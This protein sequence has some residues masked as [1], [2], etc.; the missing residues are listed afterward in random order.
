MLNI[1]CDDCCKAVPKK[2][3]LKSMF[4]KEVIVSCP[5]CK[6]QYKITGKSQWILGFILILVP[7]LSSSILNHI[8]DVDIQTYLIVESSVFFIMVI[9]SLYLVN[10]KKVS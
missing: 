1:I 6:T 8:L 2:N 3:I 9:C 7:S 4:T 10:F 5:K